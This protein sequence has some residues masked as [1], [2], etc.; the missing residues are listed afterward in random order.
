MFIVCIISGP[1]TEKIKKNFQNM[2]RKD[3]L[4]IIVKCNL[5][6]VNYLDVTLNNSDGSYKPFHKPNSEIS[7][8]HRESNHLPNIIKQLPYLSNHV[9]PNY[10][11]T[12]MYSHK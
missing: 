9:Y 7:Y 4:N 1:Q 12:K 3:N 5:K 8:I 2:F 11:L 6:I 10:H